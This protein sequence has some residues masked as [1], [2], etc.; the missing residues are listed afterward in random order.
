MSPHIVLPNP[1]FA[2]L[3]E[4]LHRALQVLAPA[5]SPCVVP[6]PR[7]SRE[8]RR[9]IYELW[10]QEKVSMKHGRAK[11]QNYVPASRL[12]RCAL[13]SPRITRISGMEL[14][15]IHREN[16]RAIRGFFIMK[17]RSR[18]NRVATTSVEQEIAG[19]LA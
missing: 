10:V 9:P 11:M 3:R 1:V 15:N 2:R 5:P 13:E 16:I 6:L 19:R 17:Y 12:A 18:A 4:V 8:T 7:I 14:P